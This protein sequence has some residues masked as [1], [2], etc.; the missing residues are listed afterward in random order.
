MKPNTMVTVSGTD[1]MTTVVYTGAYRLYQI[2][3]INS[4]NQY[5]YL[6]LGYTQTPVHVQYISCASG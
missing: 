3:W 1:R 5:I 2:D 4:M 6:Q